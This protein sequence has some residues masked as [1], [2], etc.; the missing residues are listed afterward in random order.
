MNINYKEVFTKATIYTIFVVLVLMLLAQLNKNY[1]LKNQIEIHKAIDSLKNNIGVEVI[2][3]KD[4]IKPVVKS[5]QKPQ[6]NVVSVVKEE[7]IQIGKYKIN[8]DVAE[9]VIKTFG[10]DEEMFAIIFAESGFD[11]NKINYNCYYKKDDNGTYVEVLDYSIDFSNV[12]KTRRAGDVGWVCKPNH[13]KY[14]FSK[15]IGVL[16]LNSDNGAKI[17]DIDHNIAISKQL[18]NKYG[19][20]RWTT[21][22]L[23]THKEFRDEAKLLLSKL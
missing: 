5:S 17:G 23:E 20:K 11:S 19:Y 10:H 22:S 2:Y 1:Q 3:D 16:M 9:K 6:N 21:Y 14:A 7:I 4:A 13:Q 15:D 12:S 18:L 8:R